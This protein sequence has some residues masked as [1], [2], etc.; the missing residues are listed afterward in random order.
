MF[1]KGKRLIGIAG[2]IACLAFFIHTPSWPTPDKLFIFLIFIFL[3][4]GQAK[5]LLMRLGPFV[6]LLLA[7]ESFRGLIPQLNRRVEFEWMPYVDKLVFAGELPTKVLQNWWW[8]GHVQ[9]YDFMFYLVYML[10]FI[11]PL[12]I[13]ILV[14]KTRERWYWRVISMYVFVSFTGF[15]TF[16]LYPAAP[17]W[18][19]TQT[20]VIEPV[21]RVSSE[22][23]AALGVNDF[24]LLYDKIAPNPVAA[25]PS[26]HAGYATLLFLIVAKLYGKKWAALAAVYPLIIYIGTIYMGDHY[27]IDEFLGAMYA[28]V[29]YYSVIGVFALYK[30]RF[31]SK[32][33]DE[34]LVKTDPQKVG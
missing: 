28:V 8:S 9:W 20:G 24:A 11:F 33:S 29:A 32:V 17:P 25:V 2:T 15:L 26:L 6:L 18:M 1:D 23:W 14:W 19:A 30:K 3:A 10:H 21:V 31:G 13:A 27:A 16:L 34:P 12:G 7:Y 22:V 4:L 5:E